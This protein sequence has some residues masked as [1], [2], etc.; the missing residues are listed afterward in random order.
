M[1]SQSQKSSFRVSGVTPTLET[2]ECSK[3]L[4]NLLQ[5]ASLFVRGRAELQLQVYLAVKSRLF[6][7]DTVRGVFPTVSPVNNYATLIS[8]KPFYL[9]SW[10]HE[11]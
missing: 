2:R 8:C 1:L 5:R 9:K 11:N 6:Y 7:L 4:G 3:K 10:R